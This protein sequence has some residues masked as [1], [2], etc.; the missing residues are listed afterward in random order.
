MDAVLD[1]AR[2]E[3][4]ALDF[5]ELRWESDIPIHAAFEILRY[6]LAYLLCR[7]NPKLGCADLGRMRVNV[8]GLNC[9]P[10]RYYLVCMS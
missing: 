4:I 6:G 7:A 9:G 3:E 10:T 1:L 8:L 5:S 2:I